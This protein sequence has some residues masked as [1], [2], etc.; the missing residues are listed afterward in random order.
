MKPIKI[1]CSVEHT[2]PFTALKALQGDLK[3]L[4][5]DNFKK[6]K[7]SILKHGI[8]RPVIIWDNEGEHNIL[9]GVQLVRTLTALEVENYEI[10]E[11]PVSYVKAKSLP[12]A[13]D[14]ILSLASYFGT[15]NPQGF[16]EFS[17][18]L[19]Y[20]DLE[21]LANATALPGTD[22]KAL[23]DEYTKDLTDK[24]ND[25]SGQTNEHALDDKDK[26]T[27]KKHI[28]ELEFPDEQEM[29]AVHDE[30]LSRGYIAKVK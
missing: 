26:I 27:V 9:D 17:Q 3:D 1:N 16:M 11:I 2:L 29:M 10:P 15:V 24:Q 22:F 12:D 18:D 30:L 8:M 14:K 25:I 19:P 7:K 20:K 23:E 5:T 21:D 6:Y 28:L 13:K 4:T